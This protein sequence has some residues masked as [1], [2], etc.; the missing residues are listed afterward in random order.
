MGR[1]PHQFWIKTRL[2]Q[3]E[4][5]IL[6]AGRAVQA[7]GVQVSEVTAQLRQLE[8]DTAGAPTLPAPPPGIHLSEWVI[9][10]SF[11]YLHPPPILVSHSN[12]ELL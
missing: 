11:I 1:I 12:V 5:Q 2:D 10:A 9:M 6:A 7:L 8:M 3:Q 4:E